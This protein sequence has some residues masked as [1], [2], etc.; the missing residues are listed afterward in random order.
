MFRA[1]NAGPAQPNGAQGPNPAAPDLGLGPED[2]PD[3]AVAAAAGGAPPDRTAATHS[4]QP[5][6]THNPL[7]GTNPLEFA[8][9]KA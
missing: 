9:R 3:P 1:P 2:A 5:A 6:L 7:Y 4:A 8:Q